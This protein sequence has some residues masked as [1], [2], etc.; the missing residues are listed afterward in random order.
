M[1]PFSINTDK[2]LGPVP[3]GSSRGMTDVYLFD[4]DCL[5]HSQ[6]RSV[7]RELADA[8]GVWAQSHPCYIMSSRHYSGVVSRLSE[9]FQAQLSGVFASSGTDFWVGDNSEN[10]AEHVFCDEVY[11]F[12][13]Q[14]VRKCAYPDKVPPLIDCGPG[15]MRLCL[16]GRN[17]TAAQRQAFHAFD[18][19]HRDMRRIQ[20]EFRLRFP[21][22]RIFEDRSCGLLI[23]R[24]S[25]DSS[26]IAGEI[27][28]RH[29]NARIIAFAGEAEIEG[30]AAP[31]WQ[32]FASHTGIAVSGPSD[33]WQLLRYE[34]R[35]HEEH[36]TGTKAP[37]PQFEE[38]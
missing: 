26:L 18:A 36:G 15:S 14:V 4:L 24:V 8:L 6:D 27:N 1:H 37:R 13:S 2:S 10:Q 31:L 5:A 12:L 16:I 30:Y 35:R 29:R 21:E 25:V 22:Y 9:E 38:A 28:M 33:V 34:Q 23:E 11:E 7:D 32:Q 19:E 3:F 17:P 20:D